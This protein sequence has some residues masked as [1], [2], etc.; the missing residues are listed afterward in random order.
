MEV[1]DILGY[2]KLVRGGESNFAERDELPGRQ[3][4]LG[5]FLARCS[6]NEGG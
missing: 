1:D 3:R 6:L 5:V 4:L 2:D